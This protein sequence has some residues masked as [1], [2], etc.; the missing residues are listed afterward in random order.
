MSDWLEEYRKRAKSCAGLIPSDVPG[1]PVFP[2]KYINN[3]ISSISNA[4]PGTPAMS[5]GVPSV[6]DDGPREHREHT[7]RAMVFQETDNYYSKIT[8]AT[9]GTPPENRVRHV[10]GDEALPGPTLEVLARLREHFGSRGLRE[11]E[12]EAMALAALGELMRRKSG[13][14]AMAGE[15]GPEKELAQAVNLARQVFGLE[16]EEK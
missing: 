9:P 14:V 2:Y 5:Q 13:F 3:E 12:I 11:A 6:L 8:P 15:V 16:A 4:A 10:N 1:V 7:N